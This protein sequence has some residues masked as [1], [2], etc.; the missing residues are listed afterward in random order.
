[1]SQAP[2]SEGRY[3]TVR[4]VMSSLGSAMRFCPYCAEEIQRAAIRCKHCRSDLEM[5]PSGSPRTWSTAPRVAHGPRLLALGLLGVAAL[6]LAG[7]VVARP[8]LQR[9]RAG[10][11]EPTNVVEW[12]AAMHDG[13]LKPSYVC[14]HMTTP[15][16]LADPDV[17]SSFQEEAP[18]LTE[19]VG[20][21][22]RAFGCAPEAGA[23]FRGGPHS[24]PT[25][26]SITQ[27]APLAL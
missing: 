25:P 6:A 5:A 4:P 16:M 9:F 21:M 19:M 14:E 2:G 3:R 10:R 1:M 17:A 27:G 13:C 11:C 12:H 22:R 26:G 20:R 24:A 8:L 18:H 7:P 23:L 15:K